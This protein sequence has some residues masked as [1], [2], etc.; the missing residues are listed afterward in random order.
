M[1][2]GMIGLFSLLSYVMFAICSLKT[3]FHVARHCSRRGIGF[4]RV[5][6]WLWSPSVLHKWPVLQQIPILFLRRMDTDLCDFDVD[7]NFYLSL[8]VS[9][10]CNQDSEKTITYGCHCAFDF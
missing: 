7:E 1:S 8:S 3:D 2:G 5:Q 4:R 6:L 9:H 10:S